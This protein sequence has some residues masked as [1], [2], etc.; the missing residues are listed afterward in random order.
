QQRR[1]GQ[2]RRRRRLP[3]R[4]PVSWRR[5]LE[6]RGELRSRAVLRALLALSRP[7]RR[8]KATHADAR[9]SGRRRLVQARAHRLD[10][11]VELLVL[12][13]ARAAEALED[14]EA[15]AVADVDRAIEEGRHV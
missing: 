4:A 12:A 15:A 8:R 2:R 5:A 1:I 9:G 13:E 7:G 3:E 10:R 11:A 14:D 6:L